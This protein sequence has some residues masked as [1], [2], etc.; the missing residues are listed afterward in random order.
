M[1]HDFI[2]LVYPRNCIACGNSLF[3]HEEQVCNYCYVHLPKSNFHVHKDNPVA[4]LFYGRVPLQLAGS[5]YIF[6]KTGSI[7]KILHAIKYKGNRELAALMGRWYAEDLS[8]AEELNSADLIIPVPLHTKKQ[9]QRGYNQSEEFAKGLSEKLNKPLNTTCLRRKEFTS[10]QTQKSKFERWQNVEDV[11]E[12]KDV[13]L[14]INKHV[15]LVDDVITTG[16]TLEAC[17]H[18]L[19]DVEGIKI[20]VLSIAYASL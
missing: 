8:V 17:C 14:L 1:L 13:Q 4:K 20:S 7:Q 10:T 5:F 12:V 16:A 9:K 15:I 19:Q 11:F 3:K 2:T 18:Q 6:Q